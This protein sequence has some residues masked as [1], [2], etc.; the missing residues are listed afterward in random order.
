MY[1]EHRVAPSVPFPRSAGED[2]TELGLLDETI[3]VLE[4][5]GRRS[6]VV[7]HPPGRVVVVRFRIADVSF[8]CS[9]PLAL[10]RRSGAD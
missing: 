2:V 6:G 4:L 8:K 7:G 1:P 5:F 3:A 9:D 10:T